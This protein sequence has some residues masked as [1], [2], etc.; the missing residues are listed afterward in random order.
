MKSIVDILKISPVMPVIVLHDVRQALPLGRALANGGIRVVEITLRTPAAID[1]VRIVRAAA[2]ELCVG[3]GTITSALEL[4]EAI[5]AGAH[6][7]VSPGASPALLA[8]A[9]SASV[10]FL[11]GVMTPSDVIIA[12]EAGF[13]A[14]KLFPA[15][16]AGGP[17]LLKALGAVFP[18]VMFCPT[19]GITP[20]TA[21]DYLALSNVACVGG[22]WLAPPELIAAEDWLTIEQ[23]AAAAVRLGGSVR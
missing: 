2:P 15:A 14:L 19:G 8:E 11:P 18:D 23:R 17:A 6:F 7:G 22:S 13:R 21:P 9:R 20:E 10:P 4:V 5:E 16:Q 1:A 3:V 12:R